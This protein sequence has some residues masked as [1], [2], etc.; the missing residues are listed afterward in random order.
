MFCR[1]SGFY[2]L[3]AHS[4]CSQM[5]Q[6]KC[7]ESSAKCCW[8][9]KS[10]WLGT[11]Y[12]DV[13]FQEIL[14]MLTSKTQTNPQNWRWLRRQTKPRLTSGKS[15]YCV[16]DHF[17]LIVP[18]NPQSTLESILNSIYKMRTID[19]ME[20]KPEAPNSRTGISTRSTSKTSHTFD[21]DLSQAHKHSTSNEV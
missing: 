6:T 15:T 13:C 14:K 2:L 8:R 3:D 10:S 4:T 19:F 7:L 18:F 11:I 12:L 9:S 16:S 21:L 20:V 5:H 1:V 17:P